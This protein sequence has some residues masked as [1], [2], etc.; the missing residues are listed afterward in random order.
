MDFL[1]SSEVIFYDHLNKIE[2]YCNKSVAAEVKKNADSFI[3]N[4]KRKVEESYSKYTHLYLGSVTSVIGSGCESKSLNFSTYLYTVKITKIDYQTQETV[5]AFYTE[6]VVKVESTAKTLVLY[7]HS[8]NCRAKS[9]ECIES[10]LKQCRYLK[11]EW[12][13]LCERGF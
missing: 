6:D 11:E 1:R 4:I 8:E 7:F 10:Y 13:V 2:I 9:K 5:L 3:F 12:Q